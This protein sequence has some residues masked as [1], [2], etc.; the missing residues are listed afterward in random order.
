MDQHKEKRKYNNEHAPP[1]QHTS[2][3][4]RR[5]SSVLWLACLLACIAVFCYSAWQLFSYWNAGRASDDYT[6]DLVQQ[7]V[8]QRPT[9]PPAVS[10]VQLPKEQAPIQVDFAAL[11]AQNPDVV[12]WLYS[13]DTVINYP[14]AQADDNDY[15]LYRLLDGTE[16]QNGSLFM[17]YRNQADFSDGNTLI[18]GH[19]MKTGK[20]FGTLD[21]YKKQ[22][23]FD[24]HPVMWLLTPQGDYK[25]ELAA[26]WVIRDDDPLY[27]V[28]A[29]AT[30]RTTMIEQAYKQTTFRSDVQVTAEDSLITL[31]TCSYETDIA[32]YVLLGRL[33]KLNE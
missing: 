5:T 29:D 21:N 23:Y 7:T 20:M 28:P 32:R 9:P 15:Y 26:G 4:S 13:E 24:Q 19:N 22:E 18:Y 10:Q 17:D 33:T 6:G 31:S 2:G 25:I 1:G 16:N 3:R 11:Q 27:A 12:A 8:V 14:I 30:G